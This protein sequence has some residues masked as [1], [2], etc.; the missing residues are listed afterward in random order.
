LIQRKAFS[1]TRVFED[2]EKVMPTNLHVVALKPELNEQ[3][4]LLLEM[5]VAADNRAGA[6]DLVQ[7]MEDRNISRE[8][9]WSRKVPRKTRNWCRSHHCG[10]LHPRHNWQERKVMP[11]LQ[12]SRRKLQIAIAAM[13]LADLVAVGVLFRRWSD[14]RSRGASP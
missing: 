3:N 11:E 9:S 7:R 6:V 13:V 1:W 4:Q 12:G 2:L 10:Y 14:R 8:H 5:K